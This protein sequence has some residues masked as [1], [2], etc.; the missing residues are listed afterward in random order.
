MQ[1][2]NEHNMDR[3]SLYHWGKEFVTSLK[4]GKDYIELPDVIAVNIVKFDFPPLPHYHTCFRLRE[5]RERDYVL[6]NSLEIHFL[7]MV[8]YREAYGLRQGK[9]TLPAALLDDPLARWLAWFHKSS[10]RS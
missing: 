6:T 4:A 5:E 2:R 8:K 10:S 9:K 3:R 7:N 1:I